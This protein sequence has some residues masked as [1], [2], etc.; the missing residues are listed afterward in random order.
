MERELSDG[1]EN[2]NSRTEG[3]YKVRIYLNG[4]PFRQ[5]K[6][7]LLINPHLQEKQSEIR[8]IDEAKK[9]LQ[10]DLEREV[11]PQ[12]LG[13]T[14]EE[15]FWAHCSNLQAWVEHEYDTRLLD[16]R[17]AFPLLQRLADLG[18]P[19]AKKIY[20]EE[21]FD[22]FLHG[23]KEVKEVIMDGAYL[24]DITRDQSVSLI[25]DP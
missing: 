20:Y 5:C 23:T 19:I 21:V 8:S 13:I 3:T 12:M 11:T 14:P 22:R 17:L 25:E 15:E 10:K 24:D 9:Y 4:K 16:S 7:L 6:Y 1:V 18:D 2:D